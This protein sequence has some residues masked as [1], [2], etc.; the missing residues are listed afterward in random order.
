MSIGIGAI[1]FLV[2]LGFGLQNIIVSQVTDV[3]A[4]TVLDVTTG[5][6]TLLAIDDQILTSFRS[7]EHVVGVSPTV[8][9]SGQ[10]IRGESVTD[11]GLYGIDPQYISLEGVTPI[12][13]EAFGVGDTESIVISNT[14]AQ[15]LGVTNSGDLVGEQVNV[16]ILVPVQQT[17][18][19]QGE[20]AAQEVEFENK[21]FPVTI[22]GIVSDDLSI[23]YAPLAI[24]QDNGI[25]KINL[26]R[27]KVDARE[28]LSAVRV[29]IEA[30]GFQVDSVA[31][32]VG[33]I[34]QIF[35]VFQ[36]VMAGFGLIAMF[37]ASLGAFNTLTVSLLERTRE[38]GVMKSLGT[39]SRDVYT[40]FMAES[41]LIAFLGGGLGLAIGV[42]GGQLVN[43]LINNLARRLGGQEVDL[44]AIPL[45]FLLMIIGVILVVGFIT[46]LY[47]ARRA[48]K[49]NPLD[50]LRYE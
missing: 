38:V 50:A 21:D 9:Q 47:P 23:A 29:A 20:V 12:F 28:N 49:I 24:F 39:T 32:T 7:M 1:V 37:V 25:S 34:D 2:S 3:N 16:R 22:S 15:L 45:S 42:G 8:S 18:P 43:L 27:V 5:A 35:V 10:I 26:A 11:A 13:G 44:F 30:Q 4:I 46:G 19:T 48:A 41:I 36:F 31:D 40:L 6:S 33:Q 14:T 17:E